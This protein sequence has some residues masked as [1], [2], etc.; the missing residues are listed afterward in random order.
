[1]ASSEANQVVVAVAAAAAVAVAA[2]SLELDHQ[3]AE[4]DLARCRLEVEHGRHSSMT[5]A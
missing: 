4:L 2:G 3:A 5:L 1:V